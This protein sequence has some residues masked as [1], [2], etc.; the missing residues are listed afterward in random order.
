MSTEHI[1][2]GTVLSDPS[3]AD[4]IAQLRLSDFSN[5]NKDIFDIVRALYKDKSLS[6]RAVLETLKDKGMLE[7]IGD[8]DAG[9]EDYLRRLLEMA[10]SRGI[11]SHVDR[12]AERTAR[13]S[14]REIAALI[15]NEAQDE[16]RDVDVVMDEAER[17]I[18]NLRRRSQEDIAID[19]ADV[20]AS[21]MPYLDGMRSGEI[22]PAWIPPLKALKD[23]VQYV[24][25]TDFVI[26]AGRPGD[27]KSSLLRYLA[28]KTALGNSEE[29]VEPKK[30]LTFNLENDPFEYM[31]FAICTLTGINSAK[32]KDP[33]SASLTEEEYESVKRAS[34]YLLKIPWKFVTKGHP[35]AKEIERIALREVAKGAELIQVDYLQL[36]SNGKRNRVEDL[37]ESTGILRGLS[38]RTNIPVIAASQLSRAIEGRG[39]L[40]EPQLSDL[41]ESGSIE[42]DATQV[43]FIRSMWHKDPTSDELTDPEFRFEENFSNGMVRNVVQS[44]P[45]R[46]FVRKNRNGPIGVTTPIKFNKANGRFHSLERRTF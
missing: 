6:Y 21:Y 43:W 37:A 15:A 44:V 42:Q 35:S 36:M 11:K 31:K 45:A 7:F 33:T 10:D 25:R 22:K 17:R 2:L 4:E 26:V 23:I 18:F 8:A 16:E 27:G 29:G 39:E 38:L 28:L 20:M 3:T 13:R 34:E 19:F 9:G 46:I 41:R 14:L 5:T 1:I 12:L 24:D 30:V 32:L 40:S